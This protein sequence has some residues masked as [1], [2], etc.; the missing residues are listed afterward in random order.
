MTRINPLHSWKI[1]ANGRN[2]SSLVFKER[3][4]VFVIEL[5][6]TLRVD[7]YPAICFGISFV[8]MIVHHSGLIHNVPP[9]L[10]SLLMTSLSNVLYNVADKS[11]T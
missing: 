3:Y 8:V 4:V 6:S 10:V 7:D 2:C 1:G 5:G 9:L 11:V